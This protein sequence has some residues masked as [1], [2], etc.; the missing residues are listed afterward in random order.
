VAVGF[1]AERI[2]FH[3]N[4]KSEE[5][6]RL[7]LKNGIGRIVVDN[8]HELDSLARL[9]SE[10][11]RRQQ[12]LLR[13]TPGIDP[14]THRHTTTGVTDSKFGLPLADGIASE[15]VKRAMTSVS[16]DLV[17]LHCHLGSPIFEV[18]PYAE[19][20]EVMAKFAADM[21]REHGFTWREFS[22][23]GGFAVQYVVERRHLPAAT[24]TIRRA[25]IGLPAPQP[26]SAPSDC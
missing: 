2:Y 12:I 18:E 23:G 17:G 21:Q 7:A 11:G 6:L 10:F 1:P 8:L 14:H 4:N 22:P 9:T 26:A 5:E 3:G 16:L 19:A 15:A 25:E 20:V 24:Q 13:I